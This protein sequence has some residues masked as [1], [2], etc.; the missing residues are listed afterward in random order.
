MSLT[1]PLDAR[2]R[3]GRSVWIIAAVD[4]RVLDVTYMSTSYCATLGR[5]EPTCMTETK[6]DNREIDIEFRMIKSDGHGQ[7]TVTI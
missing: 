4:L 7:G 2:V 3:P 6:K 1:F 5:Q